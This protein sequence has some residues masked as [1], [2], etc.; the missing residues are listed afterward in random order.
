V[1]LVVLLEFCVLLVEFVVLDVWLDRL[2]L[3]VWVLLWF[4]KMSHKCS[5]AIFRQS[6][7]KIRVPIILFV[8]M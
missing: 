2:L 1:F 8:K 3:S 7:Y 6:I 4:S 5:I